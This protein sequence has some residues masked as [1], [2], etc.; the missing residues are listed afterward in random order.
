MECSVPI[1][2]YLDLPD[3]I[4]NKSFIENCSNVKFYYVLGFCVVL[5]VGILI[6]HSWSQSKYNNETE[7]KKK[8]IIVVPKWLSILPL[9]YLGYYF[10]IKKPELLDQWE[11]E[12]L[13]FELSGMK[14]S[15]YVAAREADE[16]QNSAS[17]KGLLG[18]FTLAISNFFAPY[19]RGY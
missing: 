15:E 16:R 1:R 8:N 19:I 10:V 17:F 2:N 4:N 11:K 6:L 5:S 3:R 13:N 12:K 7:N 9:I 18:T 14:K